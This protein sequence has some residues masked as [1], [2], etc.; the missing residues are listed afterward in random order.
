MSKNNK[1]FE[2]DG[3]MLYNLSAIAPSVTEH[4]AR[5]LNGLIKRFCGIVVC[6]DRN[7]GDIYLRASAKMTTFLGQM[8]RLTAFFIA[9]K[10]YIFARELT[11]KVRA[12][13]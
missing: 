7:T 3:H 13:F 1:W 2:Y 10:T 12:L 9:A 11:A 5:R 6:K 8:L 4:G